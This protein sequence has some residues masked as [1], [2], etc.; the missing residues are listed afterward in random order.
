MTTVN[1]RRFYVYAYL[2]TDG[3]PY[4]IGKGCGR[5]AFRKNAHGR[6]AEPACRSRIQIL[7]SRLTEPEAFAAEKLLVSWFGRKGVESGILHNQKDGG[8]GGQTLSDE[9]KQRMSDAH[10]GKPSHRKGKNLSAEHRAAISSGLKGNTSP[11]KGK[12]FGPEWRTAMSRAAV[13]RGAP[14]LSTAQRAKQGQSHRETTANQWGI[15]GQIY[16]DMSLRKRNALKAWLKRNPQ[17]A[18]SEHPMFTKKGGHL[19][20]A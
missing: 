11:N 7:L 1:E 18:W 8:E 15:P 3:T 14:S 2:R 4:Y 9:A 17:A 16:M 6:I 12:T 20:P 5:R 10:R 19:A 13:L